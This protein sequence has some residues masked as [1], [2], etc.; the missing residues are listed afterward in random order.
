[1]TTLTFHEDQLVHL[2]SLL[3]GV[4][5]ADGDFDVFEADEIGEILADLCEDD[6]IPLE[7]SR[8]IA[9][10]DPDEFSEEDACEGLGLKTQQEKDAVLALIMR[11]A[12]SDDLADAQ[13]NAYIVRVAEYLGASFEEI[14]LNDMIEIVPPP[15]PPKLR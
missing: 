14:D 2:A 15:M 1:M 3:A 10:F 4:A 6:E 11:V 12:H 13:E 8:L 5:S 7:V 9:A